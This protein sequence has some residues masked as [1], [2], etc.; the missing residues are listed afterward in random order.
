MKYTNKSIFIF[1]FIFIFIS[2]LLLLI[3]LSLLYMVKGKNSNKDKQTFKNSKQDK[4][5]IYNLE[6]IYNKYYDKIILNE[7]D[8]SSYKSNNTNNHSNNLKFGYICPGAINTINYLK[9]INIQNNNANINKIITEIKL[10]TDFQFFI[11]IIVIYNEYIDTKL[12]NRINKQLNNNHCK[13]SEKITYRITEY[14]IV[15]QKK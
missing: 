4:L 12:F 6:K 5:N 11:E 8:L 13:I 3:L 10:L 9:N 1:I 7:F 14:L 15:S 2:I